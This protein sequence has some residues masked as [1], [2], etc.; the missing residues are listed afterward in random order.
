MPR[1]KKEVEETSGGVPFVLAGDAESRHAP[2]RANLG[3]M[4]RLLNWLID[5]AAT[6]ASDVPPAPVFQ[7]RKQVMPP[8]PVTPDEPEM[9][10]PDEEGRIALEEI[11]TLIDYID[12]KGRHSRRRI[13]LR[14]IVVGP[15]G[16]VLHAICHE[17]K[18]FRA[19]R[20]DRIDCFINHDDGEIIETSAFFRDILL[21]DLEALAP[22]ETGDYLA[23]REPGPTPA[24]SA[25]IAA[26]EMREMLR[27]P[28]SLLVLAATADND[29][30]PE[31][32][33]VICRWVEDEVDHLV[34]GTGVGLDELDA[35]T[36]LIRKM[37]PTRKSLPTHLA[38]VRRMDSVR[39]KRLAEALRDVIIADGALHFGEA[40][41]YT[42]VGQLQTHNV[43]TLVEQA[44]QKRFH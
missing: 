37:H 32:L 14:A 8:D 41:F 29:F 42:E 17:K 11:F 24:S 39:F 26:R 38:N 2:S 25:V 33:D 13:T 28:L 18:A 10:T 15:N 27:A 20:C 22:V 19:F 40:E 31:E 34:T 35:M 36:V 4:M 44:E 30:H 43:R 9:E 7:D 6:E 12:G 5:R 1:A 3:E 16:P 21:V 23:P